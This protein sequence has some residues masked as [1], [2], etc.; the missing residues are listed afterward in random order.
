M[1]LINENLII[2]NYNTVKKNS[3]DNS[4]T[5]RDISKNAAAVLFPN[6]VEMVKQCR[7]KKDKLVLD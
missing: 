6:Q 1:K 5:C 4:I 7:P 2:G 3:P